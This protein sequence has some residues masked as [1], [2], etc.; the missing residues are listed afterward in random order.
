[1]LKNHVSLAESN[2]VLPLDVIYIIM[3]Q[4]SVRDVLRCMRVCKSWNVGVCSCLLIHNFVQFYRRN[5]E[6]P[7]LLCC[8]L[9]MAELQVFLEEIHP[10][11]F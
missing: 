6:V 3:L 5:T 1:M 11:E 7:Y 4:L 9:D 8:P 2:K 10:K